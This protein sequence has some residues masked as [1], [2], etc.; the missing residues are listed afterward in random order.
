[1]SAERH[2]ASGASGE[3]G[4]YSATRLYS[5]CAAAAAPFGAC[6]CAACP[7]VRRRAI[8]NRVAARRRRSHNAL[9]ANPSRSWR[10]IRILAELGLVAVILIASS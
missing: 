3:S 7:Q 2:A 6:G 5:R 1:M 8:Q 10:H 9:V 4:K